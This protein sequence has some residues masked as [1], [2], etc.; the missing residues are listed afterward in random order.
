MLSPVLYRVPHGTKLLK[1]LNCELMSLAVC[2]TEP[3]I[4][5]WPRNI[6]K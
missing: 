5:H 6:G 3:V 1:P 4:S 2:L